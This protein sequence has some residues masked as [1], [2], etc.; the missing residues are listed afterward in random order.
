LKK[1]FW[2]VVEDEGCCARLVGYG[3]Q[4]EGEFFVGALMKGLSPYQRRSKDQ[5]FYAE[6]EE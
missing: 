4:P 2:N 5:H 3:S 6:E 1:A